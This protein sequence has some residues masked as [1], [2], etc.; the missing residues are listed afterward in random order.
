MSWGT[1]LLDPEHYAEQEHTLAKAANPWGPMLGLPT[2]EA[3][4]P[5]PAPVTPE[6][7]SQL[8]VASIEQRLAEDPAW[9][10]EAL[11]AELQ[12]AQPRKTALRAI[13][14]V[15]EDHGGDPVTLEQAHAVLDAL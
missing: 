5:T 12:R 7:P 3:D 9:W 10:P 8:S 1:R 15:A 4:A 2:D 6:E 11:V 14:T 13:L